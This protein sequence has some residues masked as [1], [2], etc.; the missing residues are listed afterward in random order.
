MFYLAT[1]VAVFVD[2]VVVLFIVA[3]FVV[4]DTV[5]YVEPAVV[6]PAANTTAAVIAASAVVATGIVVVVTATAAAVVNVNY[7]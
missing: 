3:S 1:A 5:E 6:F 7:K 4:L 2:V